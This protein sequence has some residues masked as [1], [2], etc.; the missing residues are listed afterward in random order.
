MTCRWQED[1][2]DPDHVKFLPVLREF[3]L[4]KDMENAN[5][6]TH[7]F[8]SF[9]LVWVL[10]LLSWLYKYREENFKQG[11]E[12]FGEFLYNMYCKPLRMLYK[13]TQLFNLKVE[14]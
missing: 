9:L 6:S 13:N 3:S 4:V 8:S 12:F 1:S 7:D 14:W 11:H 2:L 10:I 5:S